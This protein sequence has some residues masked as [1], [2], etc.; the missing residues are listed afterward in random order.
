VADIVVDGTI[1]VSFCTAI[2][3]IQA[4]T[5]T[6]LNA[7]LRLELT[8]TADGL[9]G[10]EA[11]TADVDNS[12]LASTFDTVTVGRA[13]F[14]GTALRLKRQT[15]VA[16]DTIHNTLTLNTT[17]FIAVRQWKDQGAYASSDPMQ[18]YPVICGQ[19][20]YIGMGE[21]NTVARY[22]VPVKITSAPALRASIA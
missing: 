22:E 10:F 21:K 8:L 18:I 4:P 7:G 1:R 9:V 19:V 12:A 6:E 5:T 11:D 15:P 20:K 14:S 16:S 2:A 17:G 13:S 3:N